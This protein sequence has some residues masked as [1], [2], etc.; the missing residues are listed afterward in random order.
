MCYG[1]EMKKGEAFG[2]WLDDNLVDVATQDADALG[3]F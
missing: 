3:H 1:L 2:D